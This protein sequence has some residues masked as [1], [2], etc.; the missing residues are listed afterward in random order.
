[1][2]HTA[3]T[4][5]VP[6]LP[7]NVARLSALLD[8]IG[9]NPEYNDVF[10]LGTVGRLHYASGFLLDDATEGS[11]FVLEL[12]GDGTPADLLDAVAA[13]EP[14]GVARLFSNCKGW[15][16]GADTVAARR[17][18]G[19]HLQKAAAMHVANVGRSL[20]QVKNEDRLRREVNRWLQ[21]N[22][23][24]DT[25]PEAVAE[26]VRQFV[27]GTKGADPDL[28]F[29]LRPPPA[30]RTLVER[31]GFWA[32]LI[33][34]GGAL[35][36]PVIARPRYALPAYAGAYGWLRF[37]E[38]TEYAADLVEDPEALRPIEAKEDEL[39]WVSNHIVVLTPVKPGSGRI[40][41]Q[42]LVLTGLNTLAR[43]IFDRG[44][45]G[46]IDSI[47]FAHWTVIDRGRNLLFMSNFDSSWESYLDDFIEKA[48]IGLTAVWSNTTGFPRAKNLV[49][50]G[51]TDGPR[52]KAWARAAQVEHGFWYSAYPPLSVRA[53]DDG[54]ALRTALATPGAPLPDWLAPAPSPRTGAGDVPNRA[55]PA[56][57]HA[58]V[59]A[60]VVRGHGKLTSATYLPVRLPDGGPPEQQT[61]RRWLAGLLP[62]IAVGDQRHEHEALQ[63]AFSA[64]GLARLGVP[65]DGIATFGRPFREGMVTP[66]RSRVLGDLAD[67]D[68]TLWAWGGG[69]PE[70]GPD[71]ERR[72]DA[73]LAVFGLDDVA[74]AGRV[75]AFVAD[76]EAMGG[77]ASAP[78]VALNLPD[79]KEHFGFVDGISQ[80]VLTGT[81]R[82]DEA[83]RWSLVAAGE[84]VLGL[85]DESHGP[86]PP[87][88]HL[89]GV[90]HDPEL[91]FGAG[92][93]FLVIRQLGQRVAEL[94]AWALAAAGGDPTGADDLAAQLVGRRQDG[95]SLLTDAPG[96]PALGPDDNDF[97][98]REHD[99]AG[100]GCPLGSHVRRANPRDTGGALGADDT[101]ESN[102]RHRVLRRGRSYGPPL[103]AGSPDDG[104]DRGLVFV[105]LVA[106]IARQFE[107]VQQ[108]WLNGPTF[109]ALGEVDALTGSQRVGNGRFTVPSR[110]VNR[111]HG[112]LRDFTVTRGGAYLFLPSMR[113]LARLAA[114]APDWEAASVD[115]GHGEPTPAGNSP[116]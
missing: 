82:A 15:P 81:D 85:Q 38:S 49:Q 5:I 102:R 44:R 2:R 40:F 97:G 68:P 25:S 20:D 57:D 108:H 56:P 17:F 35:V 112:G 71:A 46:S 92:G 90:D 28:T 73:L 23:P 109:G 1:M 21:E 99:S 69:D 29:A 12:N 13:A 9:D 101:L 22:P 84:V 10:C 94:R 58:N 91:V 104:Q 19:R 66:H 7:D 33:G 26:S 6:V 3:C 45:L 50:G 60:L 54:S 115:H 110:P 39:G 83:D 62:M 76:L 24:G 14:L 34:V 96:A 61:C 47:H 31:A 37:R 8:T 103:P 87:V 105:C 114:E 74:V 107:F 4:V 53:I 63:V 111:R 98:Y 16:Q 100:L 113:A 64:T 55:K 116:R 59:Q 95:T 72:V 77:S 11:R 32:R 36:V 41:T 78:I 88:P 43:V 42:R 75:A 52:F 106:D 79:R 70:T 93:S 48:H 67:S 18:L 30:R 27:R 86:R 89:P 80:P 51:A 65:A